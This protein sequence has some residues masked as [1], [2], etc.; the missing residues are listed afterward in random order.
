[1]Q[2]LVESIVI[3]L[4]GGLLGILVGIAGSALVAA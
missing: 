2:F 4:A 1:V 3:S